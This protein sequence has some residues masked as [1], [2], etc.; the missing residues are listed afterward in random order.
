[1]AERVPAEVF[2]PGEYLR[3]ELD[4]RGW[5]Q[6][7]FAEII[8]RPARLV[9]EI[10][11]GKRGITPATAKEIG[12]ALGTSA[13]FWLNLEAAYQLHRTEPAP[14]RIAR[15]A[16]IR[17]K[18]PVREMVKRGWVEPSES[19]EVLEARV[20]EFFGVRDAEETPRFACAAK[21]TDY[22]GEI[23]MPQLAWLN[24]VRQIAETMVVGSFS[25]KKLRSALPQLRALLSGEDE[26]RHVPRILADCG[27]RFVIA[28]ALPGSKIDGVCFWLNA[29]AP[30]IGMSLRFDRIDNFWFVLRHEIEHVLQ[31][32]GKDVPIVDSDLMSGS[33]ETVKPQEAAANDAAAEFCVPQVEITD[34]MDRVHAM[35]W[36]ARIGG[37]A[38][39]LGVHPGVVAGQLRRKTGRYD[40]F[41][42]HLAK[43]RHLVLPAAV[44]DGWGQ[45]Y[46]VPPSSPSRG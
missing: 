2:P 37:F 19:A 20:L 42:R 5:T 40:L 11:A 23:P 9:N 38:Q 28:E 32:E 17:S 30:V 39:R 44:A 21:K 27:V 8:G 16:R 25:G 15:E 26:V 13:M 34:F 45:V 29:K 31:G 36:D 22:D 46:P 7:E 43:I 12:A 18:Y 14:P 35:Y 1:M 33:A 41:N 10:I 6:A 24:R 3:D 4:A